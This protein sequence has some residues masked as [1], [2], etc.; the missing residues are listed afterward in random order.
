[1]C[2]NPGRPHLA[3]TNGQRGKYLAL[4]YVWGGDQ[5]HKTTTSNISAYEHGIDLGLLPATIRDAIHVTRA[6]GFQSLW[7]DSLCIPQNSDADKRRE[8]GRMHR[9]YRDAYLTIIAASAQNVGEGFLQVRPTPAH[10]FTLPFVCPAR[11]CPSTSTPEDLAPTQHLELGTIQ[12][13]PKF[14]SAD[15]DI[16]LYSHAS[17]PISARG[18]CMQEYFMSPRALIFT[19]QTL[20]FRCQTTTQSIGHALYNPFHERRLPDALLLPD[21]PLL[22]PGSQDLV[23]VHHAWQDLVTD[24]SR[25]AVSCPSDRLVACGALAETFS[26]V[27]RSDY[28]AGLWRDRLLAHLLWFKRENA[29]MPRPATFRAPSWS[30]ASVDGGVETMGRDT[31]AALDKLACAE[32]LLCEV[33]LEDAALPFG[34]VVAGTLV[35]RTPLMRCLL[36][37]RG[38]GARGI[39]LQSAHQARLWDGGG[40]SDD[41]REVE[42]DPKMSG[43]AYVD[44]EDDAGVQRTWAAPLVRNEEFKEGLLLALDES[45]DSATPATGKI[46]RRIG[47]L[48]ARKKGDFVQESDWYD[49]PSVDVE[50]V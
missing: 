5:V 41:K 36:V 24:Y 40:G 10:T 32:V 45:A 12:L 35:L 46:Y 31:K 49:Y 7:V 50:L 28:L 8:L 37:H 25:R 19:S 39:R 9:I 26:R 30:W 44:S 3:A 47:W 1:M 6:L 20:Q 15:G 23:G 18:W 33:T 29:D 42:V 14:T 38:A 21:P 11:P 27:L 43:W 34:Q 2:T 4:S 22:H 13:S 16:E 48:S 17:E